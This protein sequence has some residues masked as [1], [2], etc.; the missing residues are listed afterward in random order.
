[1][2]RM[3]RSQM[4]PTL[5]KYFYLSMKAIPSEYTLSIG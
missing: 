1:M 3:D 5:V 2:D 4:T